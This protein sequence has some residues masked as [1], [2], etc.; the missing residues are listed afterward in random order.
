MNQLDLAKKALDKA[1]VQ[2][3]SRS[4]TAFF[5]TVCFS[6]RMSWTDQ[7]PTAD[8][9]GK[10]LRFNP[11]FFMSLTPEGQLFLLLHETLHVV[12]Q[13]MLRIGTRNPQKWNAAC[14]YVINLL[15][16]Q[17]GYQMPE[18]GLLDK[19]FTG[20]S[21][22]QI[23]NLLPD[24]PP[25]PPGGGG[26]GGSMPG[27]FGNDIRTDSPVAGDPEL[28]SDIANILVRAAIQ[29]KMANDKPGTIPLEVE[30]Y[31]D[32]LLNPKLPWNRILQKYLNSFS[33][34]DY[35]WKKPNRRFFPEHHLPSMYSNNLIDLAAAVDISGSVSDDDFKQT[36][37]DVHAV[38]KQF[39]P[40][41]LTLVQFD[42]QLKHVDRI[43]ST[44]ELR[45]VKFHGRG[46]TRIE[47]VLAWAKDNKPQLLLIF[48][49]G[50]FRTSYE[51]PGIPV[52]WLIHNNPRFTAPFGKVIHYTM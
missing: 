36:I 18:G 14:D 43:H 41:K 27:D 37:S 20:M 5:T 34:N 46:G 6:L 17:R 3:M 24:P 23:Y 45:Q 16:M 47:P 32:K 39:K 51:N 48:S 38:V 49:D 31:L 1:K 26:S 8:V 29:S 11:Q 25:P 13:H 50:C 15:L 21:A 28:E 30:L 22:D 33:K 7:I 44:Q 12:F 4:D 52:V 42:T 35:S 2:L 9:D 19:N 40:R 10:N